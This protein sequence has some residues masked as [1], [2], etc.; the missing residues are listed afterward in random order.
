M[1]YRLAE[2]TATEPILVC[3]LV[4]IAIA[5]VGNT[6]PY[7]V[8]CGAEFA[9]SLL[10]A[11]GVAPAADRDAAAGRFE[12]GIGER[13]YP[14]I[15]DA[16]TTDHRPD[17]WNRLYIETVRD[18]STMGG[19]TLRRWWYVGLGFVCR[20]IRRA[21]IF[22]RQRTAHSAGHGSRKGE[23]M[24]V[25]QVIA[26]YSERTYRRHADGFESLWYVPFWETDR[27]S[28]D[29]NER[30]C[31]RAGRFGEASI[32]KCC[33]L[34]L[35]C[36]PPC[37]RREA[38][39]EA[40]SRFCRVAGDR[41]AADVA[42]EHAGGLPAKLEE[43]RQVPVP[44]NPATGKPFVYHLDGDVAVLELAASDGIPGI[45]RRYEIKIAT[46]RSTV[47]R[48]ANQNMKN[49]IL[50]RDHLGRPRMICACWR[51]A[52]AAWPMA[53]SPTIGPCGGACAA[54]ER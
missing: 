32:A 27:Q 31:R 38:Q 4:G 52:N 14:F 11:R 54:Y 48:Q 34:A 6:G 10:G 40:G 30:A 47:D 1:N 22:T 50:K 33:R 2:G 3:G 51:S 46:R 29:V 8:G 7:G 9:E 28:R 37:N 39:V 23:A 41:G 36:C 25:G 18:I 17:E 35:C 44:L 24:S 53:E 26:I 15:H 5:G 21:G 49:T 20:R 12:V 42:A 45:N 19:N 16:E 43:I 13:V